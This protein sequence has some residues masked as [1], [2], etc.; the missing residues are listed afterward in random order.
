MPLGE[1]RA[2]EV[3]SP[4]PAHPSGLVVDSAEFLR[5]EEDLGDGWFTRRS[6]IVFVE[7]LSPAPFDA[8]RAVARAADRLLAVT[9]H[10][11]ELA[12]EDEFGEYDGY[13]D[14]DGDMVDTPNFVQDFPPTDGGTPIQIDTKDALNRATR[15]AWLNVLAG[16]LAADGAKEIRLRDQEPGE[17]YH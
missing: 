2:C 11:R 8:T 5:P 12:G 1:T 15:S 7:V 10:G 9:F 16:E 4:V 13:S 3:G 14:V 17:R 6:E